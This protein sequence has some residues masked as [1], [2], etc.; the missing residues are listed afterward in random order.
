MKA[1]IYITLRAYVW[2]GLHI[3]FSKLRIV[4]RENIPRNGALMF[5]AN[6]QN[7]FLDALLV[8]THNG[9][10][11]HFVARAE[12]FKKPLFKWLLSLINM[13]PIYRV[14]D[15]WQSLQQ[16]EAI[17]QACHRI[18]G[19]E[20]TLLI[21]PEGNHGFERRLRPLSKGFSR[22]A[23]GTLSEYPDLNLKIV[24]VG[25]NYHQHQGFRSRVSLHYGKPI[26][27][28]PFFNPQDE[29]QASLTLRNEVS[30]AMKP[31][32][33]HIDSNDYQNSYEKLMAGRPDLS[34][35]D[36]SNRR[37]QNPDGDYPAFTDNNPFGFL[38]P[39]FRLNAILPLLIWWRIKKQVKDPVMV[40][41][42]KFAVGI[43]VFPLIFLLQSILPCLIGGWEW[44]SAYFLICILT[45]PLISR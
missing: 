5:T 24:P 11:T 31:L 22:I 2:L 40:A 10:K 6:H 3:Y 32:I 12:V 16:N 35:P 36:E 19:K 8:V 38:S 44:G 33:T 1:L 26:E 34:D 7:A 29:H 28:K 15:G 45:A 37:V 4:G 21:F 18:L 23:F 42:I 25:I 30:E 39:L 27:V 13:M 9:R 41:S 17:F 14:R 43:F 20:Q